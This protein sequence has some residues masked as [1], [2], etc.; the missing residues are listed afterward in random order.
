[1]QNLKQ[2]STLPI[3]LEY[4]LQLPSLAEFKEECVNADQNM[5]L[6][7]DVARVEKEIYDTRASLSKLK[8]MHTLLVARCFLHEMRSAS[9][10]SSTTL[11]EIGR[12]R[13]D[14]TDA[15]VAIRAGSNANAIQADD[16]EALFVQLFAAV[17]QQ[18][19]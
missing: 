9:G 14:M 17:Q 18:R 10:H 15:G 12:L 6:K 7:L 8:V 16:L 2:N 19:T 13:E 4:R 3:P 1:M 11:D 5:Q